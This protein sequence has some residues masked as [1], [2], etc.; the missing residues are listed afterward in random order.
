MNTCPRP[1]GTPPYAA[2]LV[3]GASEPDL[4][5][6]WSVEHWL[7]LCLTAI[8]TAAPCVVIRRASRGPALLRVERSICWLFAGVLA[9][10]FLGGH[11]HRLAYGYWTLDESLPIQLC[12]LAIFAT[13]AALLGADRLHRQAASNALRP[14]GGLWAGVNVWQQI[15]ELAYFWVL[16]GTLQ[17]L[18]TPD[19][20]GHFPSFICIRFFVLHAGIVVAVL[21]LTIGM[22]MRPLPGAVARAWLLTLAAAIPVGL[23]D[24]ALHAAGVHANYMYLCG[25]PKAASLFDL[26]GPWPWSL[27]ALAAVATLIF[28]LLYAPFWVLDRRASY[29]SGGARS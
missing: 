12:D 3:L 11:A 17:A 24:A 7:V 15:Y 8:L 5:M 18:L 1:G 2:M 16:G 21:V 22:R 29:R 20:E 19:V 4:F 26:M 13:I 9:L 10:A 25:P 14:R 6:H 23:V 28:G 27:A